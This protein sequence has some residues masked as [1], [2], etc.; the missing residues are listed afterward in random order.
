ML[1]DTGFSLCA[2]G[3]MIGKKQRSTFPLFETDNV[4][5]FSASKHALSKINSDF[6]KPSNS[7]YIM[8][9]IFPDR[10]NF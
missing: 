3:Q 7:K 2:N 6:L 5:C 9:I 8:T 4:T 1:N 10:I